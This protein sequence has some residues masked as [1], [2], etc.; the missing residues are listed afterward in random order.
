MSKFLKIWL[1]A[2]FLCFFS[3][4]KTF[5]ENDK[6][7]EK[8]LIVGTTPDY[9]PFEFIKNE[10]IVGFDIDLAEKISAK[11]GYKLQINSMNFASLISALHTG[12]IDFAISSMNATPERKK[13]ADFS[14]QYYHPRYAMLYRKD[15]PVRSFR[16]LDKKII[17]AQI[18]TTMETMLKDRIKSGKEFKLV[19]LGGNNMMVEELRVGRL[20]GVFVELAQAKAFAKIYPDIISYSS[21]KSKGYGCAVAFKKG[22]KLKKEFNK[23]IRSLKKSGELKK[24]ERKW[25]TK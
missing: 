9:P 19:S 8:I 11:L 17:G 18:G 3:G 5:A 23:A 20:D 1:L 12:R 21:F 6:P 16:S 15:T 10:K 7:V 13:N 4:V 24:L 14:I 25:F 22:S 2:V